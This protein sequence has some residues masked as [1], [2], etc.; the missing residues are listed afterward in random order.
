GLGGAA[1]GLSVPRGGSVPADRVRGGAGA[2]GGGGSD[3]GGD[4][5]A[6]RSARGAADAA[7]RPAVAGALPA[8]PPG[9]GPRAGGGRLCGW[10]LGLRNLLAPLVVRRVLSDRRRRARAFRFASQLAIRYRRSPAVGEELSGADARFRKGPAAGC[11]APDAP[12][13]RLADGAPA[14]VF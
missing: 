10:G 5:R 6:R 4:A 14:S 3:S 13:L 1:G 9:S 7:A 11:R 8:A 12:L 2:G